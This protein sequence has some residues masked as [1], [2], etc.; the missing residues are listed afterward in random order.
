[1]MHENEKAKMKLT[2]SATE[3]QILLEWLVQAAMPTTL[4]P[5]E[6]WRVGD[7]MQVLH[8]A[9]AASGHFGR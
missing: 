1:M 6:F 8:V 3:E 2:L 7:V 5:L 4:M 9:P